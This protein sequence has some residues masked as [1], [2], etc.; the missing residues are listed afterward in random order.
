V[1]ILVRDLVRN[2][3]ALVAVSLVLGLLV[4]G[5]VFIREGWL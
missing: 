5:F 2:V 4:T 3:A 1:K